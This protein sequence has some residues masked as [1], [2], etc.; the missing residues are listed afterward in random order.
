M[1][2]RFEYQPGLFGL[3]LVAS[4]FAAKKGKLRTQEDSASPGEN[5][6]IKSQSQS[7]PENPKSLH[8]LKHKQNRD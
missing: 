4:G 1:K 8:S 6:Q 7:E 3:A 5:G 2:R